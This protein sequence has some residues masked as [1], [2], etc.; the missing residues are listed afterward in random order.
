MK[1]KKLVL[2]V[3]VC[4]LALYGNLSDT[5]QEVQAE[6]SVS[7]QS[8]IYDVMVEVNST[9]AFEQIKAALIKSN[10]LSNEGL[11]PSIV[12]L[13][14]SDFILEQIDTTKVGVQNINVLINIKPKAD[15]SRLPVKSTITTKIQL[16]VI[17][18]QVPLVALTRSIAYVKIN[19]EFNPWDYISYI[20]DNSNQDLYKSLEIQNNVDVTTI[21]EYPVVYVATDSTGNQTTAALTVNVSK[22]VAITYDAASKESIE[23]MLTLIN[24]FRAEYGL[25]ALQLA[26]SAGQ[27]AIAI[28]AAE[29]EFDISHMRPDG[30]HY[31]TALS[32]QGVVWCH[33]PLEI[34]TTAGYT[35]ESKLNWWQNS[36]NHRA[37][38]LSGNGY[39]TIAIGYSGKMWAAIVY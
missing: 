35:I 30:S 24:N 12:D 15:A 4:F 8:S 2:A 7:L 23:D 14:K 21:G 39:D 27:T 22:N 16:H 37:I 33:S 3:A 28:R 29:A 6:A 26:D 38:L 17:D 18:T 11:N 36:P 20:F 9:D 5:I 19:T 34:L 1:L 10:L 31:K 25:P 13:E 32:D